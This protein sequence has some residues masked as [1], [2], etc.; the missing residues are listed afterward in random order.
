M[1]FEQAERKAVRPLIALGGPS[2]SGKTLSAL[3]MARGLA[4]PDG[5]I[6]MIDTERGRSRIYAEDERI[7]GFLVG[8][9][10][11]PFTSEA[12]GKAIDE[13]EKAG[14]S[15]IVV[16]SFSH[17]WSG[18]GG[19]VEQAEMSNAKAPTNWIKP[20][21]AHRR[22]VNRILQTQVPIIFCLRTK[23][24]FLTGTD[25]KGKQT[26]AKGPE[27]AEQE[28]RFIYEMTVGALLEFETHRAFYSSLKNLPEPLRAVLRDGELIGVH[29]GEAI[30]EWIEGGTPVDKDFEREASVLRDVASL[31]MEAMAKHWKGLSADWKRRLN[32]VKEECKP[33][34]E[35]ADRIRAQQA[36]ADDGEPEPPQQEGN[37]FEQGL[38]EQETPQE[39]EPNPSVND[40]KRLYEH[41]EAQVKKESDKTA[42]AGMQG[43]AYADH[44]WLTDQQ[45]REINGLFMT[46]LRDLEPA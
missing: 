34:A 19:C 6:V 25:D 21:A 24:E 38:P 23:P 46:R 29:T 41:L 45:K 1:K 2:S 37:P 5:K 39:P 18:I 27:I 40:F 30:K 36:Q 15:C 35:E 28:S 17:E 31:G 43:A 4:G 42:L 22:L 9:M 14:A 12:F 20:K 32:A 3:L 10:F 16:D 33:L 11:P 13:A 26:F 8:E 44:P 7:G